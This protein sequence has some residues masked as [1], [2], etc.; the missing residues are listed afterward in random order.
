MTYEKIAYKK[1]ISLF[2]FHIML[3][4]FYI[5][6]FLFENKIYKQ[7]YDDT[8]GIMNYTLQTVVANQNL[9][10]FDED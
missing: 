8:C 5:I 2:L 9:W 1:L 10:V 7:N 4:A 3:F 6:L